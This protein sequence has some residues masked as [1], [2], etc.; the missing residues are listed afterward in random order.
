MIHKG[1]TQK[2]TFTISAEDLKFYNSDLDFVAEPG[3][4]HVFV[5][6][7]SST[8]MMKEFELTN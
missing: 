4:F 6:T 3:M 8:E 5:G 2:V 1:E 7:D